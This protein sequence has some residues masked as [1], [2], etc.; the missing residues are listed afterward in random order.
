MLAGWPVCFGGRIV[1]L[2]LRDIRGIYHLPESLIEELNILTTG[3]LSTRS[4]SAVNNC[5][6]ICKSMTD[7][8]N[9]VNEIGVANYQC[10]MLF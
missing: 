9:T 6:L 8:V 7:I 2:L 3:P 5:V 4:N 10:G 1:G